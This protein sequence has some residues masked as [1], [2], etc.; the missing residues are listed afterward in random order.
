LQGYVLRFLADAAAGASSEAGVRRVPGLLR[1]VVR[2]RANTHVV[3]ASFDTARADD[4]AHTHRMAYLRAIGVPT[5]DSDDPE[6]VRRTFEESRRLATEGRAPVALGVG[7]S[8]VIGIAVAASVGGYLATHRPPPT[9]PAADPTERRSLEEILGMEDESDA[10][11]LRDLFRHGLPD[12]VVALDRRS[13]GHERPAPDDVVSRRAAV[14]ERLDGTTIQE[15][16]RGVLAAAEG[17]VDREDGQD[18]ANWLNQ[19]VLLHDALEREEVPFFVDAVLRTS[20][21]GRRRLLMSSWDVHARRTFRS[22]EL[23]IRALEI[24]RLD[25]LDF[26]SSLLGYTRP[27]SRYALIVRDEIEQ[28]LV[29]DVLPSV[30]ALEDSVIVRGYEDETGIGWVTEF[31]G[32][33]HDDLR[34]ESEAIVSAAMPNDLPLNHLAAAVVRRRNAVAALSSALPG[35]RLREPSAW[36]YDVEHVAGLAGQAARPAVAEL[37][38]AERAVHAEDTTRAY[39]ILLDARAASVAEHEAQHRLDYESDRLVTVPQVL[40]RYTGDTEELER[41]N[42][43][44]ERANAELS[45]YLAQIA[46]RS[47]LAWTSFIHVASFLMSRPSWR[48]PEAYAAAALIESLADDAGIAHVDLIRDRTVNRAEVTRIYGA[49]R[50][51]SA[52]D[53]SA[54][55]ARTWSRLYA[56][57]LPPLALVEEPSR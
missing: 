6:G 25:N 39:E 1:G 41:V 3:A 26:E 48:M 33:A 21:R 8:L 28:F 36:V 29:E 43:W 54:L 44:A 5:I 53:L 27:E 23:T 11:P 17:F 35:V 31:E 22:G 14:L 7:A 47:S 55:A 19:L 15:P 20:Y 37:R 46:R 24:A 56:T 2:K 50:S 16:M 42:R 40:A 10:H 9:P 4:V 45:A 51:R 49:L 57:D 30:H 18:D 12:Y 52:E 34:R 38:E 32:W 13:A